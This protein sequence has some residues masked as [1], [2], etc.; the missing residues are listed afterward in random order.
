MFLPPLKTCRKK[1]KKA[2]FVV[3]LLRLAIATRVRLFE[4]EMDEETG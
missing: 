2:R 1:Q 4:E 3:E